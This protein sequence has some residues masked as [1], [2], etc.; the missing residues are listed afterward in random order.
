MSLFSN[1]LYDFKLITCLLKDKILSSVI[2]N[3][4]LSTPSMLGGNNVR[5]KRSLL[6]SSKAWGLALISFKLN[7]PSIYS[8]ENEVT[9]LKA[10]QI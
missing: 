1:L 7:N 10:T 5:S 9:L 2:T 3:E 6:Y 8:P 4:L